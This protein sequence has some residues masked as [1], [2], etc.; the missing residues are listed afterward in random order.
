MGRDWPTEL[1]SGEVQP[2]QFGEVAQFGRDWACQPVSAGGEV[3]AGSVRVV[4]DSSCADA[5]ADAASI[6]MTKAAAMA[7]MRE[8]YISVA[9]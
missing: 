6:K 2:F 1:V 8:L 5:C 4:G 9:P 3:A 7:K